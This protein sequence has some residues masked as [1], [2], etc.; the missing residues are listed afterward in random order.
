MLTAGFVMYI[1]S[2]CHLEGPKFAHD[3]EQVLARAT[4]AGIE[5]LVAIGNGSG[6]DDVA[7]GIRLAEQFSRPSTADR[8]LKIYATIGVHPHEAALAE[9]RHFTD[10][11]KV[12]RDPRGAAQR[13]GQKP[14]S[15]RERRRSP[16][17]TD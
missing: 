4:E 17:E 7:C 6:P 3:R 2:H 5:A 12:A 16:P 15:I 8:G 11:E 9:E 1:D 14:R 13:S 10:M